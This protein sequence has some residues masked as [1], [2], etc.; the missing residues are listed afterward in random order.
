MTADRRLL[1]VAVAAGVL[2][3]PA[4]VGPAVARREP[5]PAANAAVAPAP[6]PHGS[7]FAE[8]I[9]APGERIAASDPTTV[10]A[11][12]TPVADP[13][14]S[15][16]AGT[17]PVFPPQ[18]LPPISPVPVVI[19]PPDPPLVAAIRAYLDNRPD[20][21]VKHLKG[22]DKTNQE[23]ML[24][25]IPA[26]VRASQVDL[27]RA[28]PHEIGVLAGQLDAPA[29]ALATRGPL[30]VEKACFC[31]WV[32]NFGRYD[33]LP[34]RHAFPPGALAELY[35]E[36]KNVPSEPTSSPPEGDGYV[37]R[38]A[39][40]LQLRDAAGGVVELTDQSRKAVP[41]LA[42]TKRDFTRSPIR[43]Y[44]LLFRFPVPGKPGE[45]KVV[46]EVRDPATG[47]AVSKTMPFRV[48]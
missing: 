2:A 21:A 35:L 41:A 47:R 44:F 3:V 7:Q 31:R 36:V 23:L 19:T 8:L 22:L 12:G 4:C 28:T 33:P 45:Y 25:L 37:T 30:F 42:E 39:C 20:E 46:V 10:V 40:T 32:K 16:V 15:A 9:H 11:R 5:P 24:Q 17:V 29:A 13:S 43:D 14:V 27:S 18:T 1:L 6:R 26:L 34:D 38:L 48:Q